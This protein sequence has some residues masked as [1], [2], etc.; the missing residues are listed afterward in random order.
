MR[1][2]TIKA[3]YTKLTYKIKTIL[4]HSQPVTEKSFV[5][6]EKRARAR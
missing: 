2:T 6:A 5:H 4:W 3:E 1:L